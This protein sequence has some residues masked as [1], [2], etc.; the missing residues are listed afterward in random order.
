[1]EDLFLR[2][3]YTS[4]YIILLEEYYLYWLNCE[5]SGLD[6][7]SSKR[8][9]LAEDSIFYTFISDG[10]HLP[11]IMLKTYLRAKKSDKFITINDAIHMAELSPGNYDFYGV[12][13]IVES[14]GLVHCRDSQYLAGSSSNMNG[15]M[16]VIASLREL[17]LKGLIRIGHDNALRMLKEKLALRVTHQIPRIVYDHHRFSITQK[18]N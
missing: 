6:R 7:P 3:F 10:F 17:D 16:N 18:S 5:I 2:N 12:P 1:L 4:H 9:L 15:C 14:N 13:I 8:P 11:L